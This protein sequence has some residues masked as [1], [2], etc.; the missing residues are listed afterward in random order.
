MPDIF[1][2]FAELSL[3]L[4]QPKCGVKI[5]AA[6]EAL[7]E[8]LGATIL[9]ANAEDHGRLV[10]ELLNSLGQVAFDAAWSEGRTM[11]MEQAIELALADY[12]V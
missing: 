1:E 5:A 3:E 2:A 6:A 11:T 4:G 12:E 7:R 9:P 10:R 8:D